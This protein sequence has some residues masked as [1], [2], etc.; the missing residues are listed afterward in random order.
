MSIPGSFGGVGEDLLDSG[1][2]LL[3][4]LSTV[5]SNQ[6]LYLKFISGDGK[7]V[8]WWISTDKFSCWTIINQDTY[9]FV[10]LGILGNTPRVSLY[11]IILKVLPITLFQESCSGFQIAAS[12]S[13]SC[14]EIH[15]CDPE[16]YCESHD[17]Y[18][19]ENPPMTEKEIN[20]DIL[21]GLW[22]NLYK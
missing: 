17:M 12:D 5:R 4:V 2:K 9:S 18:T 20:T 11:L 10:S 6:I 14:S 8:Y 21:S 1:H 13:I 15:V 19:G 3:S 7:E 16:N 22:N